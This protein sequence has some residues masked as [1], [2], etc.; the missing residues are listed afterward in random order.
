MLAAMPGNA[1]D[2]SLLMVDER[3][4]FEPLYAGLT[5]DEAADTGAGA[6]CFTVS[7]ELPSNQ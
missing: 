3:Y 1:S 2:T 5:A 6:H 4:D 7:T